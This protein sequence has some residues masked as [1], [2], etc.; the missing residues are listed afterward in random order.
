M[1]ECLAA[2][3]ASAQH[4]FG[5]FF[6][7]QPWKNVHD[8]INSSKGSDILV[9]NC[10]L[11]HVRFLLTCYVCCT[12]IRWKF[13]HI[14]VFWGLCFS[15]TWISCKILCCGIKGNNKFKS[16]LTNTDSPQKVLSDTN[17]YQELIN[18]TF[19]QKGSK[20]HSLLEF[21]CTYIM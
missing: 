19:C 6:K 4:G 12:K 10:Y 3:S 15:G 2:A 13:W 18:L 11:C 1:A 16:I 21:V 20:W 7:A 17:K 8:V 14:Q 5:N 9:F